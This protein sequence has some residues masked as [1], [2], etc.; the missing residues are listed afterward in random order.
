MLAGNDPFLHALHLLERA[1]GMR[2]GSTQGE[3]QR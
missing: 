2:E 1:G 3:E